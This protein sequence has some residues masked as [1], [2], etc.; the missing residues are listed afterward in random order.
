LTSIKD[1]LTARLVGADDVL[2]WNRKS[3]GSYH[4]V[5]ISADGFLYTSDGK[6]HK[7]PSGAA[8]HLNSNKPVDGWNVWKLKKTGVALSEL[9][10]QLK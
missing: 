10:E 2:I 3:L 1:L 7:S 8:R 4:E 5:V 6:S 9:R